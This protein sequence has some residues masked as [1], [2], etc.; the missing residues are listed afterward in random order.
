LS[1]DVREHLAISEAERSRPYVGDGTVRG[2]RHVQRHH[3]LC[4]GVGLQSDEVLPLKFA[5]MLFDVAPDCGLTALRVRSSDAANP[6]A[7]L[8]R[9]SDL[10]G[11][12]SIR[13]T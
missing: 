3:A 2:E 1:L 11:S 4:G 5:E 10:A 6:D 7:D 13:Q 9:R 8:I 12:I